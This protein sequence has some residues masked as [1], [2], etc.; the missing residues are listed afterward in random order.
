MAS[1]A[2]EILFETMALPKWAGVVAIIVLVGFLNYK[3]EQFIALMKTWGTVALFSAY[4]VFGLLIFF[5]YSDRIL[6]TFSRPPESSTGVMVLI[7]TGIIYVGYNL[8]V[9]PPAFFALK[10]FRSKS[11][12]LYAAIIS[13]LLM[14]LPWFL[15][16]VAI[17]AFYPSQDVIGAPVPWL[18]MLQNMGYLVVV[19]FGLVV[20]WTLVE[21]ATGNIHAFITRLNVDLMERNRRYLSG[22][23]KA[24][25]SF[26]ALILA[27]ALSSVGIIDLIAKGYAFMGYAMIAFYAI[28][29]TVRGSILLIRGR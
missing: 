15:T 10:K 2:G 6:E 11:E 1:A 29:L 26:V 14:T 24:G 17:M 12:S 4:T 3:G 18:R 23:Q 8:S 9:F 7:W 27:V 19:I 16:F 21:T 25:V 28:P 22:F 20:G 5:N 13:G